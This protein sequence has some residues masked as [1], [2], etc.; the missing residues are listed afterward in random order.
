MAYKGVDIGRKIMRWH[1]K[2][3]KFTFVEWI[4]K[5]HS[6]ELSRELLAMWR[7]AQPKKIKVSIQE[8]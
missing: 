4:D 7:L 6:P 8:K 3:P 1:Y 2:S 5:S